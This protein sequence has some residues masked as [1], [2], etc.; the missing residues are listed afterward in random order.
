MFCNFIF[1][2]YRLHVKDSVS[3]NMNDFLEKH[4]TI[5]YESAS[6]IRKIARS[7]CSGNFRANIIY[8]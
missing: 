5:D 7:G 2:F 4:C 1:S 6:V 3:L 8:K